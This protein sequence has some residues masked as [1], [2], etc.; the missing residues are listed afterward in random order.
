MSHILVG[1]IAKKQLDILQ[2]LKQRNKAFK[3]LCL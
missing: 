3:E 2:K 1:V